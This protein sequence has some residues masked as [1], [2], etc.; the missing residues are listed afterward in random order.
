MHTNLKVFTLTTEMARHAGKMQALSA[1][2]VANADTPDYHAQRISSFADQLGDQNSG[3]R[4]T[5]AAHLTSD[6]SSHATQFSD[7]E[8]MSPNGNSVSI[9]QEMLVSV[10]AKRQHDRA[11][12]IYKSSMNML[13]TT[14]GR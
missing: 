13:R 14:L 12:A 9:E 5:R 6:F 2:N 10:E 7:T 3:M 4:T 1:Q 8:F 11:L